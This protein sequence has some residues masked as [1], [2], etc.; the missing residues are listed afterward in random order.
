[1]AAMLAPLFP[2]SWIYFCSEAHFGNRIHFIGI[3]HKE[4]GRYFRA[5]IEI[6]FFNTLPIPSLRVQIL[7]GICCE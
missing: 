1:M 3:L 6:P 7:R 4:A 2:E 5:L